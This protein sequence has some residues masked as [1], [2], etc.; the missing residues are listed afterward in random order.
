LGDVACVEQQYERAA[1]LLGAANQLGEALGLRAKPPD[2]E[3]HDH[4]TVST[5]ARLGESAFSS[6]WAEG[7]AMTL[8]QAIEYALAAAEAQHT[9]KEAKPRALGARADIL[10]AREREVATLIAHGLTNREIA[11]ELQ[12]M[13]RTAETH[14]L[15]ILNKLKVNSRT[16]IAV[17]AIAHG[18]HTPAIER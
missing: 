16:Q 6:A 4:Y 1:R 7:R 17:W 3:C 13:E 9:P 10:T 8:E 18:L 14:V 2:Q 15:N 5:R 12:F 11:S